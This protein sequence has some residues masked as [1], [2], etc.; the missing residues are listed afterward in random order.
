MCRSWISGRTITIDVEGLNNMTL[1]KEIYKIVS[2]I[3]VF[4][5]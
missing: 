2:V 4:N 1:G 3:P 5:G